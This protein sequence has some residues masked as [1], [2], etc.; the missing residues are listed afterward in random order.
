MDMNPDTELMK[1]ALR[2]K[3]PKCGIGNLY[4]PGLTLNL[5]DKCDHCGFDLAKNDS[6]DGPA[7][8]LI[9]ILSF[10]LVPLAL[11][12]EVWFAPPLWAHV[13]VWT[14]VALAITVGLLRPIKAYVIALQY[15]HRSSDWEE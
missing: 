1:L 10:L 9:F 15:K 13:I 7:V 14:L 4:K 11:L 6:A 12:V 8:F 5:A 3:C 2:Q